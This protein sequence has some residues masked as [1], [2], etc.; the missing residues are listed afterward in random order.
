MQWAAAT[1][2]IVSMKQNAAVPPEWQNRR[3]SDSIMIS[4][5]D[6]G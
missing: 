3:D 5:G 4:K 1:R 6:Q 2:E